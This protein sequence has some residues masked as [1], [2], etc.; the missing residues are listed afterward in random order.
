MPLPA[1]DPDEV[2]PKDLQALAG[3][4]RQR[5]TE[6]AD[7]WSNE[8][9]PGPQDEALPADLLDDEQAADADGTDAQ[10]SPRPAAPRAGAA[11]EGGA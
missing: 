9:A 8:A 1:P 2:M 6:A 5:Y 3:Y 4:M 7:W 10:D 11:G